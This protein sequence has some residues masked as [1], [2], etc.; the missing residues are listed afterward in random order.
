[1]TLLM[2]SLLQMG[3]DNEKAIQ[4]P[5]ESYDNKHSRFKHK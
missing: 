5:M 2:H 3:R 1:M 4:V